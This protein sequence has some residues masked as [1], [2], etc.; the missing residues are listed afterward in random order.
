ME[1]E[2]FQGWI[3]AVKNVGEWHLRVDEGAEEFEWVE[4]RKDPSQPDQ[5]YN[6]EDAIWLRAVGRRVPTAERR[7]ATARE[8]L[9]IDSVDMATRC[10][11]Y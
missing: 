7:T 5:S 6:N 8:V 11:P 10:D 3:P 1:V 4:R 9:K 2:N